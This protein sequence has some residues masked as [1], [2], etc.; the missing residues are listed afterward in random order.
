MTYSECKAIYRKWDYMAR[1]GP[2][3][4]YLI[5]ESIRLQAEAVDLRQQLETVKQENCDLLI[6]HAELTRRLAEAQA[7]CNRMESFCAVH[8][9]EIKSTTENHSLPPVSDGALWPGCFDGEVEL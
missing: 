1:L 6:G 9:V 4:P 5:R 2:I 3:E 8:G 7:R